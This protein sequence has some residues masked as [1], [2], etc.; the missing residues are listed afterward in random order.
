MS[1][2]RGEIVRQLPYLRRYARALLGSQDRGDKYVRVCL[3]ALIQEPDRL[4]DDHPPRVQLFKL[5]HEVHE[6][7]GGAVAE[8]P[9][10][11]TKLEKC[12][13]GLPPR[14]RQILLLTAL[15]GLSL[16]EAAYALTITDEEARELL[17]VARAELTEQTAIAVLVIEDEPMIAVD[18]A[19]IV[20]EMGHSV[21]G[22]A[23][24]RDEAVKMAA[25]RHP[26]IILADIKLGDG[27]SGIDAVDQILELSDVPVVFVTAYPE[28]LLTGER[29]EPT[30]LVTKPF[31]AD[32]L[33]VAIN[34]A[35]MSRQ[36]FATADAE[37]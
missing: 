12:I 6:R 14:Q 2:E 31:E 3:E 30:Y 34:Q 15:E 9:D 22:T 27:S 35:L 33:K 5:F 10:A 19:G 17:Q 1:E 36:Q 37:Q 11:G 18:I 4:V 25:A 7:F 24:T 21:V 20:A 16:E 32:S 8:V 13:Q 28:R 23:A 29:R 26:D